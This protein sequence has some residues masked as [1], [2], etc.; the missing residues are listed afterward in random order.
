M[1]DHSI[2]L[3][4]SQITTLHTFVRKKYVHYID[5]QWEIVD[6]L[7]CAIE[8]AMTHDPQLSFDLA[9]S[10]VYRRYP[11]TGFAQLV[12]AKEKSMVRYWRK[13]IL[14]TLKNYLHPAHILYIATLWYLV[15]NFIFMW[16]MYIIIPLFLFIG[17]FIWMSGIR[18]KNLVGVPSASSHKLLFL[19]TIYSLIFMPSLSGFWVVFFIDTIDY[20]IDSFS[21][22]QSIF[23]SLGFTL[24]LI[25]GHC[26][27]YYFPSLIQGEV[28]KIHPK[29]LATCV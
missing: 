4:E 29:I 24:C 18:L 21:Q 10:Q 7:A 15:Y 13:K 3:S 16:G 11:I 28:S 17:V 26:M 14:H 22:S 5:V 2:T 6:H 12:A 23:L 27:Y 9:L 25:Y 20:S 19:H 1:T 8:E